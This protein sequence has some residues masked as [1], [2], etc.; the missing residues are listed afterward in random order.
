[1]VPSKLLTIMAAGRPVLA[2][3][4][5]AGDAPRIIEESGAGIACEAGDARGLA[6]AVLYLKENRDAAAGMAMNGR[7]FAEEHF[8]RE[9]CVREFERVFAQTAAR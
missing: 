6:D 2:S 3:M 5:L 1:V 4:P 7:R 9:A 8:S